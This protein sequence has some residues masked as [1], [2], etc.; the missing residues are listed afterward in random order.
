MFM[1]SRCHIELACMEA[2]DHVSRVQ[3]VPSSR[4]STRKIPRTPEMGTMTNGPDKGK[5]DVLSKELS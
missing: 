1:S 5:W 2:P 3:S 4:K